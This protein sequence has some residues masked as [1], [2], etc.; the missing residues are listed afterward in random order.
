MKNHT[1]LPQLLALMISVITIVGFFLPYI[2][3]TSEYAAYLKSHGD[4]TV[5]SESDVKIRDLDNV[6]MFEYSKI[7]FQG[8][9]EIFHDTLPGIFYGVVFSLPFAMGI[10]ALLCSLR[11]HATPLLFISALMFYVIRMLNWDTIDRGIMPSSGRTWGITHMMYYPCAVV[12][13]VC[14]IWLFVAKWK[15]KKEARVA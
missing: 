3:S 4:E 14:G 12:L 8:G 7:Y 5:Y 2:S 1:R 6:S 10:L 15:T 11:K 9:Q 13:F